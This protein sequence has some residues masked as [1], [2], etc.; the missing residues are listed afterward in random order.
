[1]NLADEAA[2]PPDR[3]GHRVLITPDQRAQKL[4]IDRARQRR[5]ADHIAEQ[6]RDLAALGLAG[7][8]GHGLR[9]GLAR[10]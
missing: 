4:G 5:R 9:R 10:I 8:F 7:G 2:E 6:N 3:A 1:M